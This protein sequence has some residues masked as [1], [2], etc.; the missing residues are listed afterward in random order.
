MHWHGLRIRGTRTGRRR[1]GVTLMEVLISIFVLSIGML[2][3]AAL[4]PIGRHTLV[5]TA[6]ADRGG[7]CGRAAMRILK[8]TRAL[9]RPPAANPNTDPSC[10]RWCSLSSA[11]ITPQE[12]VCL[13]PLG[14]YA[15]ART[16]TTPN[17]TMARFPASQVNLNDTGNQY[18]MRRVTLS[19]P[20]STAAILPDVAERMCRWQDDR[21]FDISTTDRSQRPRQML[22]FDS[23]LVAP[24]PRLYATDPGI[25]GAPISTES[26]GS[27]SWMAVIAPHY[28]QFGTITPTIDQLTY[29]VSVVVFYRRNFSVPDLNDRVPAERVAMVYDTNAIRVGVGGGRVQLRVDVDSRY[30]NNRTWLD[31]D[32]GQWIMLAGRTTTVPVM[33]IFRWYRVDAVSELRGGREDTPSLSYYYR[34]VTLDGPDWPIGSGTGAIT[35][36]RAIIMN[37]VVGVYTMPLEKESFGG[38]WDLR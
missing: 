15:G 31:L 35:Q 17:T 25:S 18:S 13:D 28:W 29:N 3:V 4:I 1:R 23:D 30:P 7:A 6:K 38:I 24:V 33:T 9:E 26:E 20:N 14:C 27:Y 37:G 8:N 21:L 2:G 34:Y 5:E 19:M 36:T 10:Y 11:T 12:Y 32:R 16:S 22:L